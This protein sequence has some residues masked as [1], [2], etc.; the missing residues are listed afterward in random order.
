MKKL[1]EKLMAA[2]FCCAMIFVFCCAF[3]NSTEITSNVSDNFVGNLGTSS[4]E[5]SINSDGT[6]ASYYY[7]K[8]KIKIELAGHRSP[9]GQ[10][11]LTQVTQSPVKEVFNGKISNGSF[12]GEWV[13]GPK[14][15]KLNF[16]FHQLSLPDLKKSTATS[17]LRVEMK[18]DNGSGV[19]V[20]NLGQYKDPKTNESFVKI[21]RGAARTEYNQNPSVFAGHGSH[22]YDGSP[23]FLSDPNKKYFLTH[24][25]IGIDHPELVQE[26]FAEVAIDYNFQA[27]RQPMNFLEQ[28]LNPVLPSALACGPGSFD[29]IIGHE[30]L[31]RKSISPENNIYTL[32]NPIAL[33][34]LPDNFCDK[35]SQKNKEMSPYCVG[36][37]DMS[38]GNLRMNIYYMP[39][40]AMGRLK[41]TPKRFYLSDVEGKTYFSEAQ[42]DKGSYQATLVNVERGT[43]SFQL[44][45]DK[46]SVQL[47]YKNAGDYP[48]ELSSDSFWYQKNKGGLKNLGEFSLRDSSNNVLSKITMDEIERK[49]LG[50]EIAPQGTLSTVLFSLNKLENDHLYSVAY[51]PALPPTRSLDEVLPTIEKI[52]N[53]EFRSKDQYP[54]SE[55]QDNKNGGYLNLLYKNAKELLEMPVKLKTGNCKVPDLPAVNGA[56]YFYE[57]YCWSW[58]PSTEALRGTPLISENAFRMVAGDP[59]NK[60]VAVN[61]MIWG[62][63]SSKPAELLL[64]E[65]G[66]KL[67]SKELTFDGSEIL[68]YEQASVRG[69]F[70]R[71]TVHTNGEENR[72]ITLKYQFPKAWLSDTKVAQLLTWMIKANPFSP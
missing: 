29:R 10:V 69:Y 18:Y 39:T 58:G 23:V 44:S 41:I 9:E 61:G 12:S 66:A 14:S 57:F 65:L 63:I 5:L 7:T 19:W 45:P 47:V 54:Y 52:I 67:I 28:I 60:K 2:H 30:T 56:P 15:K 6:R 13:G 3:A 32:E 16:H 26:L 68:V 70:V 37:T 51:A 72:A 53:W 11:S 35:K 55:L 36:A 34:D 64:K 4:V 42:G 71:K 48:F 40:G 25:D 20:W 46:S 59:F 33:F 49:N 17:D 31:L 21:S 43:A 38:H 50:K 24:I 1:N 62:E 22:S 8:Y 27:A